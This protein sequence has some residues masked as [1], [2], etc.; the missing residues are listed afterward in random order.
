MFSFSIHQSH[1]SFR[2]LNNFISIIFISSYLQEIFLDTAVQVSLG[3]FSE[4]GEKFG[5]SINN[6][7]TGKKKIKLP[8]ASH[9]P[10]DITSNDYLLFPVYKLPI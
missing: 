9:I 3:N 4:S 10:A 5:L 8:P 2:L 1:Y 7:K 6:M